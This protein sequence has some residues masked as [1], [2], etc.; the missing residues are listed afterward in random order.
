MEIWALAPFFCRCTGDDN[1]AK[2]PRWVASTIPG[3]KPRAME[4]M[5]CQSAEVLPRA[6]ESMLCQC[7]LPAPI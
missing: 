6:I 5:L 2:A 1:G 3:L 4:F 7:L